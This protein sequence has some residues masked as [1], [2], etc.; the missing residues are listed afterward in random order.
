MMPRV[1]LSREGEREGEG[2]GEKCKERQ[3]DNEKISLMQLF[4]PPFSGLF[5]LPFSVFNVCLIVFTLCS[6]TLDQ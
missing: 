6:L 4:F 1:S 2:R 5:F 3:A